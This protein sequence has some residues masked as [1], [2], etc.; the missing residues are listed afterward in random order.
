VSEQIT[1]QVTIITTWTPDLEG[2]LD[3]P[4]VRAYAE[5][6]RE[7][8]AI[9]PVSAINRLPGLDEVVTVVEVA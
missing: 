8:F 5:R 6:V 2:D 7:Q 9:D 3:Y 1:V 4:T